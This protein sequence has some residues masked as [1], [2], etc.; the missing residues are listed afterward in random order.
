MTLEQFTSHVESQLNELGFVRDPLFS[1]EHFAATCAFAFI[2]PNMRLALHV[3][4]ENQNFGAMLRIWQAPFERIVAEG[5][6]PDW[7]T[8]E[9]LQQELETL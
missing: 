8:T 2:R 7:P 9:E 1:P 5:R 3:Y 4:G 6:D